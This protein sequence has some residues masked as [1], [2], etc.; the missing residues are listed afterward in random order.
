[1]LDFSGESKKN[2]RFFIFFVKK[3]PFLSAPK[4][5]GF[6]GLKFIMKKAK[7]RLRT[8]YRKQ[9]VYVEQSNNNLANEWLEASGSIVKIET[10]SYKGLQVTSPTTSI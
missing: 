8:A 6:P 7:M 3:E 5:M 4:G 2:K 9:R 1:M 10:M